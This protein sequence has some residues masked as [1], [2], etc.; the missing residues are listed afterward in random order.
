MIL[1]LIESM[2]LLLCFLMQTYKHKQKQCYNRATC[3]KHADQLGLKKPKQKKQNSS[4]PKVTK[5]DDYNFSTFNTLNIKYPSVYAAIHWSAAILKQW[6]GDVDIIE[7]FITRQHLK[8]LD[9]PWKVS[10][11]SWKLALMVGTT[12]RQQDSAPCN[13]AK[14][15]SRTHQGI[16]PRAQG[17]DPIF[18][19][20]ALNP[21]KHPY[22]LLQQAQTLEV[23]FQ[24]TP[25]AQRPHPHRPGMS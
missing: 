19:L 22:V 12:L 1:W 18:K 10:H 6:T 21:I 2:A 14:Q 3:S 11:F 23:S 13:N 9:F 16:W 17:I 24:D 20:P 25:E 15:C 4:H 5:F 7:D 8:S